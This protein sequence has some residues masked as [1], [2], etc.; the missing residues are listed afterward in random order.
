MS[1][2]I[3]VLLWCAALATW[4]MMFSKIVIES[5]KKLVLFVR[6][7]SRKLRRTPPDRQQS[8]GR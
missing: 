3:D 7:K 1:E 2:T 5:A 4:L 8:A 6:G